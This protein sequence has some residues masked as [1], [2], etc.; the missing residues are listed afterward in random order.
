[1]SAII[2]FAA[3]I[4][5]VVV[6]FS[7]KKKQ[8]EPGGEDLDGR[9]QTA[10]SGVNA[11]SWRLGHRLVDDLPVDDVHAARERPVAG[12]GPGEARLSAISSTYGSVAFVSAFVDVTGTPPGMFAT[13]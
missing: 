8:P 13:Q 7:P 5:W 10:S 2:G 4:T 9:E 12:D 1:M 6:R 3:G 11:R